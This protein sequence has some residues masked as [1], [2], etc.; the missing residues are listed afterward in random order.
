MR[1]PHRLLGLLLFLPLATWTTTGLVFL[2]E[3]GWAGAYET[4]HRFDGPVVLLA[5]SLLAF[6]GLRLLRR[7]ATQGPGPSPR[8]DV[9][10]GD[11]HWLAAEDGGGRHPHP[12]VVLQDDVFNRSRI[13]TVVVC[14]LTSNL[15]RATEPG[16]VLL[17]RGE[18][19]LP[20]QSV[21][22]VSQLLS[23]E[24]SR[25]GERIGSLSDERVEQILSG[26]RF[27]QRSYFDA[28]AG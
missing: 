4:L 6:T 5:V 22:V 15:H 18:A 7:G 2:L 8:E 19:D 16:N 11:V 24:K 20:K 3:P 14:A 21:V 27:Q 23:V 13:S 28:R 12:H 10:R 26:L 1:S 17:D 9:R 25:L